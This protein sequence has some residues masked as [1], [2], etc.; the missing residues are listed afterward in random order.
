MKTVEKKDWIIKVVE[1]KVKSNWIV[2]LQ[3][4]KSILGNVRY[5]IYVFDRTLRQFAMIKKFDSL[6]EAKNYFNLL[7]RA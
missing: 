4:Q 3:A 1:K 7:K 2:E 5:V 6:Q